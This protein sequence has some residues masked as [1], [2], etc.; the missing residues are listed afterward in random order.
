M[1][2]K[3]MLVMGLF[4]FILFLKLSSLLSWTLGFQISRTSNIACFGFCNAYPI[5]HSTSQGAVLHLLHSCFIV[6]Q[7]HIGIN[8]RSMPTMEE[9]ITGTV[10][11]RGARIWGKPA[12]HGTQ[13]S[14]FPAPQGSAL[15]AWAVF[16]PIPEVTICQINSP[17]FFLPS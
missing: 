13:R 14:G 16:P 10:W 7:K 17:R 9:N 5:S 6:W 4:H 8:P 2:G 12:W 15:S 3:K 1:R 11:R